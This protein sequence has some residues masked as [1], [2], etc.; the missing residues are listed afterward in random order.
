M[1]RFSRLAAAVSNFAPGSS[2]PLRLA[3]LW[4]HESGTYVRFTD[5][6]GGHLP[7]QGK[8]SMTSSRSRNKQS[9]K[10]SPKRAAKTEE[11][12]LRPDGWDRFKIAVNA[13]AKSG[14]MHRTAKPKKRAK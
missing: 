14:P 8:L 11:V 6:G 9:R 5:S 1:N 13:A 3:G 4:R 12:E 7:P 2:A 10:P